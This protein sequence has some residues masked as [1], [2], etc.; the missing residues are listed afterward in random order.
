[1]MNNLGEQIFNLMLS[2]DHTD[3]QFAF[4]LAKNNI[5]LL[6]LED[7]AVLYLISSYNF[8]NCISSEVD[9]INLLEEIIP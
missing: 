8:N 4:G 6:C 9:Y 7:L 5:Q 3:H 2:K 1:M